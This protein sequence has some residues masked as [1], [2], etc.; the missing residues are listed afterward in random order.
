MRFGFRVPFA[1]IDKGV[2]E[3]IGPRGLYSA[4]FHLSLENKN[5]QT[6]VVYQYAFYILSTLLI[7]LV[8]LI[9]LWI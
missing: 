9:S 8:A 1:L 2:I 5:Y 3:M 7:V 4:F 6:G